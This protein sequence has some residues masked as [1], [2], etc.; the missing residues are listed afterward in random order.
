M[1]VGHILEVAVPTLGRAATNHDLV[2]VDPRARSWFP[3]SA[4]RIHPHV[5]RPDRAVLP[6]AKTGAHGQDNQNHQE[7]AP[8]HAIAV[9]H[10]RAPVHRVLVHA[11]AHIVD[12]VRVPTKGNVRLQQHRMQNPTIV[13]MVNTHGKIL[14]SDQ[15]LKHPPQIQSVL[16]VVSVRRI[17]IGSHGVP[18][19]AMHAIRRTTMIIEKRRIAPRKPVQVVKVVGARRAS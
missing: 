14:R 10:D 4:S 9:V 19:A 2:A 11:A 15:L 7:V 18:K 16:A 3:H 8:G 17:E 12:R 1:C 5:G 13:P 6:A